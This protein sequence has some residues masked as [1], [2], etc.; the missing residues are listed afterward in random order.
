MLT[1]CEKKGTLPFSQEPQTGSS[2][3]AVITAGR[4][5]KLQ[6]LGV[7]SGPSK[8]ASSFPPGKMERRRVVSPFYSEDDPVI[9]VEIPKAPQ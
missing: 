9:L 6:E 4:Y 5:D 7:R 2:W 1:Q 3:H 8:V